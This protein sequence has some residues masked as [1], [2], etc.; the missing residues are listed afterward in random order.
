[1]KVGMN[2][3]TPRRLERHGNR[4]RDGKC[5]YALSNAPDD[6]P[7]VSLARQKCQRFF[8]ERSNQDAKSEFGWDEIQTAKYLAWQHH[9]ALTIL[10]TWFI[11]E[12]KLD[13]AVDF[14]RDPALLAKYEVEVLPALSV[15]NV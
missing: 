14:A 10:A 9:L 1:M 11:A 8:I 12:T 6:T 7:L 2:M 15:A 13:W 3:V 4:D 5:Y